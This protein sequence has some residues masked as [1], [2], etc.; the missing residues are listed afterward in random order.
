[1][2][3]VQSCI[4]L[5][6]RERSLT[7]TATESIRIPSIHIEPNRSTSRIPRVPR[8]VPVEVGLSGG[9]RCIPLAVRDLVHA[10]PP[11]IDFRSVGGSSP[12][13]PRPDGKRTVAALAIRRGG[14]CFGEPRMGVRAVVRH[15]IDH[16]AKPRGARR[17]QPLGS[18]RVP[19]TGR[20]SENR[21]RRSRRR[22]WV[23]GT[24]G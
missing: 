3:A 11:K 21:L 10:G 14:Q 5:A 16:H 22:T 7:I 1:M 17:D 20:C 15:D 9:K 12:V 24:T 19:N 23:R 13:S 6:D 18:S 4:I 8:V 2:D